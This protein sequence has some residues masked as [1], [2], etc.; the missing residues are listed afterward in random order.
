MQNFLSAQQVLNLIATIGHK[1]TVIVEGENGI[2][3]T[4]LLHQLSVCLSSLTTSL[5]TLS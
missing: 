3:K 2:G 5:L 4:A 1:R